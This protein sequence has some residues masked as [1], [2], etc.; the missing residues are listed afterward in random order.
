MS[1]Q[2]G[3][4]H[5]RHIAAWWPILLTIVV[6]LSL[7]A[8]LML[9][10]TQMRLGDS[11]LPGILTI[12]LL[13]LVVDGWLYV[14]EAGRKLQEER[15]L[16]H[17]LIDNIP[18]R[19]FIK[20]AQGRRI[21][22]N[23]ADLQ[24]ARA[25]KMEQVVGKTVFELFAPEQASTFWANDQQVLA[26]GEPLLNVEQPSRDAQGEVTWTLATEV[27]LRD[28]D[29]N[30]IG[31]VGIMRDITA[32]KRAAEAGRVAEERYRKIV[33]ESVEGIYQ[34]TPDGR[35]L[36]VNPALARMFG[37]DSPEEMT[38]HV[39]DLER[40]I[41]ADPS[42]RSEFKKAVEA[43]GVVTGFESE[44]Y[45]KDGRKLWISENGRTVCDEHGAVLY[46]EGTIVDI[47]RRKNAELAQRK[48]E[49]KYRDFFEN[50]VAGTF[51]STTDGRF[52][53]A[54]PALAQM[55]GY[56]EVGELLI[57]ITDPA[58]Q[59][60]ARPSEGFELLK[61]ITEEAEVSGLEVE[62][63]RKDGSSVWV[64]MNAVLVRDA[65]GLPA[66]LEGTVVDITARKFLEQ[67]QRDTQQKQAM[68]IKE[69]EQRT[70]EIS[71]LHEMSDRV[72]SCPGVEEAYE[73]I[74]EQVPLLFPADSG[75]LYILD[76]SRQT[77]EVKAAWGAA[78]E[79]LA[80]F[81]PSDC[82]SLQR[83]QPHTAEAR[84]ADPDGDGRALFCPYIGQTHPAA[85][86]CVP[87]IAQGEPLGTLH[88]R[89]EASSPGMD[90]PPSGEAWY[91]EAKRQFAHVVADSLALSISNL[92]LRESLRQQSIRDP[93]T[94]MFNRRYME[95]SLEREIAR[96][97]R[98]GRPLAVIM[99]DIDH[100]KN[101]NDQF[102]HV[103]GDGI[104]RELG[105]FF[106]SHIRGADIACRYG[107]EEFALIMP[108]A[109][110][111]VAIQRATMI[112]AG[113]RSMEV[114]H[115]G[116]SFGRVTLSLG[117]AEFPG[118]G[119]TGEAVIRQADAALY[120]AKQAGRNRVEA[121]G[122]A[123]D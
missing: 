60:F 120:R 58:R 93:L 121:A 51:Q 61:R 104:L 95:E 59:L 62:L 57:S 49:K 107:G 105:A 114:Q 97:S 13:L 87:L 115:A 29:Q 85:C 48:A 106:R 27:P 76:T 79:D 44:A 90:Q 22:A 103:A 25:T 122:S 24:S 66:S 26:T 47:T 31:L 89:R 65:A 45:G 16:L 77:A 82:W 117:V 118:H 110:L 43:T 36:T 67:A 7:A 12:V 15:N 8:L 55:L 14:R 72:Q 33:E 71:L 102:G 9:A 10:I 119:T 18:D 109:S 73:I 35:L 52:L 112:C 34:S 41:Y 81:A 84:Q 123:G 63:R 42:R 108:E 68:W 11:V 56:E 19:I 101:F 78:G 23:P 69:L 3:G 6:V 94:G 80:A 116:L 2:D 98:A 74:G 75:A 86:L 32:Y 40:R 1:K 39:Q 99:M 46:Y 38:A 4:P 100:F 92:N 70:R 88:L 28:S 53:D 20:D 83:G 50:S 96:A 30:V 111:E 17:V 21:L 113:A 54:N 5:S 91:T 64:L 37:Y